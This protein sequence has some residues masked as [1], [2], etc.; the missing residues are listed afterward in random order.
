MG[1]E[2]NEF[3][4]QTESGV[5]RALEESPLYFTYVND[6]EALKTESKYYPWTRPTINWSLACELDGKTR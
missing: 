3:V 2:T 1:F 6:F 5:M 4:T